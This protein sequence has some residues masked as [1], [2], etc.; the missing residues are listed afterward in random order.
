MTILEQGDE[1]LSYELIDIPESEQEDGLSLVL[2]DLGV[3]SGEDILIKVYQQ[4]SL[5][6]DAQCF[7]CTPEAIN[8]IEDRLRDSYG[9]GD[10]KLKIMTPTPR[11]GK[12]IKRVV[13]LSIATPIEPEKVEPE[14]GDDIGS[15][16][17]NMMDAMQTQNTNM[18]N[19]FRESQLQSQNKTQELII[20]MMANKSSDEKQPSFIE[21]LA[22]LKAIMPEPEKQKDPMESILAMLNV[23]EKVKE[24]ISPEPAPAEGSMGQ[25]LTMGSQLIEAA[26]NSP[27]QAPPVQQNVTTQVNDHPQKQIENPPEQPDMNII[28]KQKLKNHLQVLCTKAAENRNPALWADLT[29]DEIP[30]QFY[31]QLIDVLGS[32]DEVAFVNMSEINPTIIEHREWFLTFIGEIRAAFTDDSDGEVNDDDTPDL[33]TSTDSGDDTLKSPEKRSG[34][35]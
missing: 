14:K 3:E 13:K 6:K 26:K 9:A 10:Y 5:G 8:G 23:T 27:K 21:Q 2:E 17:S 29:I 28:V 31:P 24:T 35:C 19:M 32:D 16:I 34:K 1:Q 12:S 20:T 22:A 15:V 7:D 33:T 30:E 4:D 25:L 18:M 11:G